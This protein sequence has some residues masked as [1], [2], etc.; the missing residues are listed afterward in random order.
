MCVCVTNMIIVYVI[1]IMIIVVIAITI[2]IIV[3]NIAITIMIIAIV[4]VTVLLLLLRLF[5]CYC[6]CDLDC[7]VIVLRCV[8]V[9]IIAQYISVIQRFHRDSHR[10]QNPN[11]TLWGETNLQ[12]LQGPSA[13]AK[14]HSA[15]EK[16][17]LSPRIK[18]GMIFWI[19]PT[20]N[21]F[22]TLQTAWSLSGHAPVAID[23]PQKKGGALLH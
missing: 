14:S 6:Y 2:L 18:N 5:K 13:V 16:K 21:S 19:L 20:C 11:V 17:N 23:T 9:I 10:F 4:I 3:I 22:G 15:T 7:S 8:I 12:F 1:T